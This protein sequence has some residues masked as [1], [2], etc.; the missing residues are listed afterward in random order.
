VFE[1]TLLEVD[2]RVESDVFLFKT[3]VERRFFFFLKLK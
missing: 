2:F 1:K 3:G